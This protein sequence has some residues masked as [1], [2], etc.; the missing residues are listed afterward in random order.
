MQQKNVFGKLRVLSRPTGKPQWAQALRSILLMILAVLIAKF[1]GW[2]NGISAVMFI[3]ILATMIIDI[4]LPLRKVVPLAFIGFI[5]AILAFTSVSL[6]LNSVPVFIF[7]TIIWAF[8]GLSTYI[9]GE[10]VGF[11]GFIIFSLYFI[12]VIMVNYKSTTTEWVSYCILAFLVASILLIPRIFKIKQDIHKMVAVGFIPQTSLKTVLSTRHALSGIPLDLNDYELFRLGSYI[13]GFRGYS[14]LL[15]LRISKEYQDRFK[16]V[17]QD[18]NETSLKIAEGIMKDKKQV[19]LDNLNKHLSSIN[20]IKDSEEKDLNAF[21]NIAY[22]MGEILKKSSELLSDRISGE[23]LKIS[24]SQTSFKHVLKAN[25]NLKNIY[26]R[27]ALRFALAMTIGLL[28]VHLTHDRDVI[29]VTMGILIIIKPDV[30]STINNMLV[31]V[32]FNLLAIIVAIILGFI[33]PH[34]ILLIFAFIML[35][36]FRAFFPTYMGLSVMALTVFVVFVWPTGTVF[37]NALARIIDITIGAII[38]FICAYVILPSRVTVDLPG[39]L[40][41]TIKATQ[42]YM[43]SVVVTPENYS[44]QKAVECL[45]NYL[46]QENNLEAA[47]LK[48]QDFFTDVSEDIIIY[49]DLAAASHK[50]TA[51][52]SALGTLQEKK[53][54]KNVHIDDQ[55]VMAVMDNMIETVENGVKSDKTYLEFLQGLNGKSYVKENLDQYVDWVISDVELLQELV[56]SGADNG[57]FGRYRDLT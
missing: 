45:N 11:F 55:P 49:Q 4:S 19:N 44:H 57:I 6:S 1:L 40:A 2:D 41:S 5:M 56:D 14:K 16:G 28:L 27:H 48:L 3:T 15:Y 53:L 18:I 9:F 51:D 43:K 50:L 23:K 29:W 13:T 47:I 36:L 37:D 34:Q 22:Q 7:F 17:L 39:Q 52:I 30:T 24:T 21:V 26:I 33:F 42:D 35:F 32:F 20:G 38:S 8:F 54:V 46:L 25:F 12:A 31:R 10:S